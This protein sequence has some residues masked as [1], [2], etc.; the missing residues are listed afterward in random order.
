[1]V[2]KRA[3]LESGQVRAVSQMFARD[4]RTGIAYASTGPNMTAYSNLARHMVELLNVVCGR[5]PRAGEQ[6]RRSN[7]QAPA[8]DY[9][10]QAI[11]ASRPWKTDGAGRI[12][13]VAQIFGE[14][15]SGTLADEILTPGDG[16]LKALIVAGGNPAPDH[17]KAVKALRSRSSRHHRPMDVSNGRIAGRFYTCCR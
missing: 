11:P 2:E 17:E 6:V 5:F 14:K 9:V 8:V 13:G 4:S 15:L 3:G 12:R 1:M 7:V 10:E 16:Q